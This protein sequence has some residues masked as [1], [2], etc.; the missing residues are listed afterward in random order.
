MNQ[1]NPLFRYSETALTPIEIGEYTIRPVANAAALQWPFGGLVW[2]RP[3]AIEVQQ[4]DQI[5]RIPIPDG[6][7]LAQIGAMIAG[8][9]VALLLWWYWR[10]V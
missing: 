7:R 8:V 6:T 10:R 9:G 2:N 5:E 1:L 4:G 3:V